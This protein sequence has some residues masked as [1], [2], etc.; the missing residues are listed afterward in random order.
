MWHA[1]P[2]NAAD[3]SRPSADKDGGKLGAYA[4]A[5][6]P[7]GGYPHQ[8]IMAARED[9]PDD[10]AY[11]LTKLVLEKREDLAKVHKEALN[12]KVENQKS[13]NAGIPWHPA[14]LRYFAEN[15][16]Q[17]GIARQGVA[18]CAGD[19]QLA[20]AGDRSA[21]YEDVA[22]AAELDEARRRRV[23]EL[24]EEEEGAT[25]ALAGWLGRAVLWFAAGVSILHPYAAAAGAPPFYGT[26]IIATYTLRPLRVGL[27]LALIY[28]LFF[29][30]RAL[31]NRVT[32]PDWLCAAA[33]LAIVGYI[34]Y[35]G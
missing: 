1:R 27:V 9:F 11:K 4:P 22:A 28:L 30:R 3:R 20:E 35:Q 17:A 8:D 24:I 32:P 16:Y 10:L 19:R 33:S 21:S 29:M 2:E 6:I 13:Q 26:P 5:T 25:N 14:A 12:I 7:K 34:I 23:E 31:R 15:E 18:A